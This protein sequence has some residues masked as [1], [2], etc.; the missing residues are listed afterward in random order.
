[1]A[2]V[3]HFPGSKPP[4]EAEEDERPLHQ[5]YMR[6][7][8]Y[9]YTNLR[10]RKLQPQS[11]LVILEDENGRV[12]YLNL[13]FSRDDAEAAAGRVIGSMKRSKFADDEPLPEQETDDYSN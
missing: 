11:M 13:G 12:S 5:R 9:L 4:V 7:M 8:R 6:A 1:M 2:E 3:I 10:S